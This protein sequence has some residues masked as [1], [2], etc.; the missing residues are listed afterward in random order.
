MSAAPPKWWTPLR[1]AARE[2]VRVR[3]LVLPPAGIGPTPMRPLV[4]ALP[5]DVEVMG[6]VLPGRER[7]RGEPPGAGLTDVLAGLR[8][9]RERRR[10]PTVVY[11]HRLGAL[12]APL[13]AAELGDDC[14]AVVLSEFPAGAWPARHPF[15]DDPAAVS[16]LSAQESLAAEPAV[17]EALAPVLR[18]DLALAVAAAEALREVRLAAPLTILTGPDRAPDTAG[19]WRDRTRGPVELLTEPHGGHRESPAGRPV[20]VAAL[21]RATERVERVRGVGI[22]CLPFA[23]GG[24]GFFRGWSRRAPTGY[25]VRGLQLP[26]REDRLL[27]PAVT[28]V[29]AAAEY[30]LPQVERAVDECTQVVLFGHSL[31]AVLGFELALLIGPRWPGALA[32]L[33]ASGSAAP[34]RGRAER[35]TGLDDD[36]FV[37]RVR[38]FA[39]H[40]DAALDD[41]ELRELLLPTLRADVAMHEAYRAEP[42]VRL[43]VPITVLRGEND[44]LVSAAEA[45][46]WAEV[47]GAPVTRVEL[48]GGHMYLLDQAEAVLGVLAGPAP[49]PRPSAAAVPQAERGAT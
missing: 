32:H 13:V 29:R 12:L 28:D 22:L 37:A 19:A 2:P 41:P 25:T 35:A 48:P 9:L 38:G 44:E 4:T 27:E 7:R 40:H 20:T 18:A 26:G 47:A 6:L 31:G 34:H 23:G 15:G 21:H 49:P 42:G 5:D 10:L 3:L 14:R 16:A 8:Q 17:R 36:A 1:R 39:G 30:L 43:D 11:G 46:G 45:A 24:A 33:Y